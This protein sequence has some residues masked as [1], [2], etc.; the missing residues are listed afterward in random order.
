MTDTLYLNG[1]VSADNKGYDPDGPDGP[2]IPETFNAN[3]YFSNPSNTDIVAI[4]ADEDGN[5]NDLA[6]ITIPA[7]T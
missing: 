5:K 3:V 1:T 2:K 4:K 7:T 6:E